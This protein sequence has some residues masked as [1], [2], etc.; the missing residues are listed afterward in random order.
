MTDKIFAEGIYF[1]APNEKAPDFVKGKLSFKVLDAIKFLE[2]NVNNA[3]YVN[4]D[5]KE[6]K[7]GKIYVELNTFKV[8]KP[9]SLKEETQEESNLDDSVPF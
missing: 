5:I 6:S 3:G 9:E 2:A 4:C 7:G 1:S 8:E